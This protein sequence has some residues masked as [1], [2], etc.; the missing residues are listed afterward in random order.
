MNTKRLLT[1][2]AIILGSVGVTLLFFPQEWI[3]YFLMEDSSVLLLQL[4]GAMYFAF[5][6]LNWMYKEN[7]IGGIYGRPV[8]MANFTHFFIA[9]LTFIKLWAS[10]PGNF[11]LIIATLNYSVFAFAFAYLLFFKKDI[12]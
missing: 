5:A 9:A 4:I 8:A 6:M 2:I 12:K 10:D 7:T 11:P 3:S 1:V